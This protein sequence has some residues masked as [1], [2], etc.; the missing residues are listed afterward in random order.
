MKQAYDVVT[1]NS[2]KCAGCQYFGVVS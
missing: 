1:M 2:M